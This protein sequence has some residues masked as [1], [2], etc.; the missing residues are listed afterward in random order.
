[1]LA[2]YHSMQN[3]LSSSLV[4][5]NTKVKIYRTVML[6]VILYG[7]EAWSLTLRKEHKL[8][9]FE[10]RVLRRILGPK[11]EEVTGEWRRLHNEELYAL[12][13]SPVIIG[14][15]KL[16]IMRWSGHV[17]CMGDMRDAHRV[18][19]GRCEGRRPP[20]R[21]RHRSEDNI[22]IDFQAMSWGGMDCIDVAQDWDR[23]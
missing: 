5:K 18:L 16:R 20:G 17:A 10:N 7:C 15:L 4:S 23:W 22:K 14:V 12:H 21:C 1:M 9:V 6:P 2:I 13:A 3:L 19:V 11:R 8:R